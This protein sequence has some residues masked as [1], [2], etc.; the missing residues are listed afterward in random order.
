MPSVNEPSRSLG[1]LFCNLLMVLAATFVC[2]VTVRAQAPDAPTTG[3]G[4]PAPEAPA[5]AATDDGQEIADASNENT[6]G[7]GVSD[8]R[9]VPPLANVELSFQ[10]AK[11]E[12]IMKWLGE[13]TGKTII[14][15]P[16]VKCQLNVMSS[17]KRTLEQALRM[18]YNALS[19]E[20]F[21]AIETSDTIYLVPEKDAAKIA[22]EWLNGDE[23][24]LKGKQRV[25]KIF[26]L[27]HATA[28]RLKSKLTSALSTE[29]K[30]EVDEQAN[31]LIITDYADNMNLAR[32]FIRELDVPA[33]GASRTDV[34]RPK[35]PKPWATMSD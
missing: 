15:H 16:K 34:I 11:I 5:Q 7:T 4:A 28:A 26:P 27:E 1:K 23:E 24:D 33:V 18:V 19:L 14:K 22:P 21:S 3:D 32:E 10:N 17:K 8:A 6:T 13:V 20:G 35:E 31:R 29:A 25:V 30:I 2:S 12:L 9:S